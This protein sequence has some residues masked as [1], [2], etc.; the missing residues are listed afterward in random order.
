M[1]RLAASVLAFFLFVSPTFG[2]DWS[3]IF[4]KTRQ[5][6]VQVFNTKGSCTAFSINQAGHYYLTAAHC[7]GDNLMFW[8]ESSPATGIQHT[9]G[10]MRVIKFSKELDLAILEGTEGMPALNRGKMPKEGAEIASIGYAFGEDNLFL[11]AQN[12]SRIKEARAYG[13]IRT[14]IIKDQKDIGGMSGGPVIDTKGNV[15]GMVQQ[16]LIAEDGDDLVD[17]GT[18]IKDIYAWS[19]DF[20]EN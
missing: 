7:L 9:F 16:G 19:R 3:K 6:I 14:I 20:W 15:V 11:F 17:Y 8:K 5:S 18:A 12:V 2:Y 4:T 13:I 10:V 1:K